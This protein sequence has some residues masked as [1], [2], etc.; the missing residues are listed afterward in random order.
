MVALSSEF[1]M[2]MRIELDETYFVEQTPF[3]ARRRIDVFKGGRFE[4]PKL[5][6]EVMPGGLDWQLW[7]QDG[8]L[9]PDVRLTLKTDDA[10][11]IFVTY[12]GVRHAAPDVM[13]R[14]ATDGEVDRSE[15]YLRTALF[16]EAEADRY[17][18]LNRIV[19]VGMGQRLP[20]AAQYDVFE[21]L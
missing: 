15:Y 2:Q 1:L 8:V 6:G 19:A 12:R 16:F 18:W 9:H 7:R 13:E 20:G 5:K 14:L 4:G 17:D 11:I 10:K 3:G 21:I